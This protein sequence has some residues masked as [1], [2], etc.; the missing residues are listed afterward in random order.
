MMD[1]NSSYLFDKDFGFAS[2]Y[3]NSE[4]RIS[5]PSLPQLAFK[6]KK[7]MELLAEEMRV[8]YV[9]MTR[10]KEKLI[11]IGSVKN[12]EKAKG[13]WMGAANTL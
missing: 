13:K 3:V 10:A 9:A 2:K 6:R 12:A 7:K 5:Y 1:L 4:K 11:L 8:L